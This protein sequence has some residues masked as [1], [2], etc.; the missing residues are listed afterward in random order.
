MGDKMKFLLSLMFLAAPAQAS[1]CE[2]FGA[3]HEQMIL[4]YDTSFTLNVCRFGKSVIDV[5]TL[6]RYTLEKQRQ[7]VIDRYIANERLWPKD[8]L[9]SGGGTFLTYDS[10]GVPVYFCKYFDGSMM[11]YKTFERGLRSKENREMERALK[12]RRPF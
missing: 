4:A 2:R 3:V 5:T 9:S 6:T 11:E 1:V 8:C 10:Q 12:L 7:L